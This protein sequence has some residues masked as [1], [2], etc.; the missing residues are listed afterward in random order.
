MEEKEFNTGTFK[1]DMLLDKYNTLLNAAKIFRGSGDSTDYYSSFLFG[2]IRTYVEIIE[3]L[4]ELKKLL[5]E[6]EEL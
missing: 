2:K 5:E 1:I 3:D 4:E 6:E